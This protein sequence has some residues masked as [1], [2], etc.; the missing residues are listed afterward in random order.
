MRVIITLNLLCMKLKKL[1]IS[2]KYY[3]KVILYVNTIICFNMFISHCSGQFLTYV[4]IKTRVPR[5][6]N[7]LRTPII[8]VIWASPPSISSQS[9]IQLFPKPFLLLRNGLSRGYSF[10]REHHQLK[11]VLPSRARW[12]P[13]STPSIFAYIY[14]VESFVPPDYPTFHTIHWLLL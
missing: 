7:L 5:H 6:H 11:P 1:F 12:P 13:Q 10:F 4:R 8:K 2:S 9:I 3:M 14:G